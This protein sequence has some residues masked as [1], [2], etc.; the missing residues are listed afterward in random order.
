[1]TPPSIGYSVDESSEQDVDESSEQDQRLVGLM[2]SAQAGETAAY[3]QL[4]NEIIPLLRR[5]VRRQRAFLQPPDVE[6]LV[7]DILLSLHE[8]RA[9]YDPARPFLPWLMAIARNRVA[10]GARRYLRR[11][12][13]EVVVD[14]L[15]ETFPGD[16]PN[17]TGE[18]F[19]DP[20][21]LR[22]A[23]KGLPRGQRDAIEM[24]KLR[25]MSLKEAAVT[26]GASI[27]ALKVAVHRGMHALRKAL[28]KA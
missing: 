15:P 13:N 22:L 25:E 6:D 2:R 4:L 24:L 27:A 14:K 16:D 17:T 10:D 18:V 26:S 11:S 9:T 23:M 8:A 28:G 5:A 3:A 21:A 1:L 20:E 12:A 19:G 7:Q